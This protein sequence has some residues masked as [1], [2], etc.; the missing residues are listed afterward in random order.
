MADHRREID[1]QQQA[2]QV[3]K[4]R[5]A[6]IKETHALIEPVRSLGPV[7][8]GGK[9][10]LALAGV[11]GLMLGLFAAFMAEFLAKVRQRR[12]ET[13]PTRSAPTAVEERAA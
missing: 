13:E 12:Q 2:I 1:N 9:V 5:L 11:L 6:N 3:L 10:I 8:P 4:T 7:G